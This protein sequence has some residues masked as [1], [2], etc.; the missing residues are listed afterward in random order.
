MGKEGDDGAAD[1]LQ[2]ENGRPRILEQVQTDLARL[3]RR[4]LSKT[5]YGKRL[6]LCLEVDI[7]MENFGNEAALRWLQRIVLR[8]DNL[9][10][11]LAS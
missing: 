9:H 3:G 11:E 8:H 2:R 7:R 5:E 4:A 6:P 10:Q 1:A